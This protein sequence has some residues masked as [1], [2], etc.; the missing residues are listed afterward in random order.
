MYN[1]ENSIP[2]F[3]FQ[4]MVIYPYD[5]ATWFVSKLFSSFHSFHFLFL[6]PHSALNIVSL[7]ISQQNVSFSSLSA[8][9]AEQASDMVVAFI[10]SNGT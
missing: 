1:N 2:F 6:Q 9:S 4:E 8:T 5:V 7:P 3:I 10:Q